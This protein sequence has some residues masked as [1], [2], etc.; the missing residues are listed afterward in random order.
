M[1]LSGIFEDE[2][3]WKT[4]PPIVN[5]NALVVA[6]VH[7]VQVEGFEHHKTLNVVKPVPALTI[8]P[9]YKVYSAGVIVAEAE[10][11]KVI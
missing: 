10:L 3:F 11:F 1:D 5:D 4:L 8:D 9:L 6:D 2:G 7:V